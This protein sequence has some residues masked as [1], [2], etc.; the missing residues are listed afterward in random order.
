[1]SFESGASVGRTVDRPIDIP[2]DIFFF[3]FPRGSICRSRT[4]RGL[5]PDRARARPP[6]PHSVGRRRDAKGY[7]K[8]VRRFGIKPKKEKCVVIGRFEVFR[9]I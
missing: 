6:P 2:T 7:G 8:V 9:N 3:H 4:R 1:L 5:R